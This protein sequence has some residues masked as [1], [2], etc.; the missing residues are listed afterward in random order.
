MK[1][2]I[3]ALLLAGFAAA[4]FAQETGQQAEQ[5]DVDNYAVS[6]TVPNDEA[7]PAGFI[8]SGPSYGFKDGQLVRNGTTCENLLPIMGE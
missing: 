7:C 2:T 8:E 3:A 4:S 5:Q 6:V 1:R